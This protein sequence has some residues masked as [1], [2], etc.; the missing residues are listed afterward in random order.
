MKTRKKGFSR[1]RTALPT[2]REFPE[3]GCS[4][5]TMFEGDFFLPQAALKTP[6]GTSK[7]E[8]SEFGVPWKRE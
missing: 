2:N 5:L 6:G 1:I 7:K 3:L 4:V 8:M